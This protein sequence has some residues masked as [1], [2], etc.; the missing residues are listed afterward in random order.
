MEKLEGSVVG[1]IF[2]NEE[3]GYTVL[4]VRSGRSE[5]TVIGAMPELNPGEQAV[6]T[7]EWVEHKSYGRQFRCAS[8]EIQTPTTLLGIERYLAGGAVR[9]V[10]P[11]TARQIVERFGEETMTVLAEHP[12]RLTEISGIGRK[13]ADMIA[14]S[15]AAQQGARQAIIYLQSYGVSPALAIHTGPGLLGAIVEPA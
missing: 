5:H 14:E 9:G 12:E 8:L 13:R 7:G 1:T 3:N 4:T 6:F 10:G 11:S 15:F 2:R